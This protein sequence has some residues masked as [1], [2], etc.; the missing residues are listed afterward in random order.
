MAAYLLARLVTNC[1][2][3]A[4]GS[5]AESELVIQS[6]KFPLSSGLLLVIA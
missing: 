1:L 6:E 2:V 3:Q 5:V 4:K